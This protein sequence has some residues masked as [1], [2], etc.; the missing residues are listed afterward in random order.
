[1]GAERLRT[2]RRLKIP[3]KINV[4]KESAKSSTGM[5]DFLKKKRE[6]MKRNNK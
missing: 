1:M 6:E 2:G 5:K 4:E 3:S